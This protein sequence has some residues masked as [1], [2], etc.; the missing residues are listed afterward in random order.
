M[1]TFLLQNGTLWD[2]GLV[3]YA[4]FAIGLQA[5]F[6]S[7]ILRFYNQKNWNKSTC[8]PMLLSSTS[9]INISHSVGWIF[10]G[11]PDDQAYNVMSPLR[12]P[13]SLP[14]VDYN[15]SLTF[16]QSAPGVEYGRGRAKRYPLANRIRIHKECC[17]NR[18]NKTW[19]MPASVLMTRPIF[20]ISVTLA[21]KLAT[22]K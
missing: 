21:H 1:C 20:N 12:W 19:V 9:A 17:L 13:L 22:V 7:K 14:S 15:R 11:N 16:A 5:S 4:I 3:H 6:I 10:H 2:V 18:F 8:W